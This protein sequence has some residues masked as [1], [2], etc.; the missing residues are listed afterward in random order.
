[1]GDGSC[2]LTILIGGIAIYFILKVEVFSFWEPFSPINQD[3]ILGKSTFANWMVSILKRDTPEHKKKQHPLHLCHPDVFGHFFLRSF[4]KQTDGTLCSPHT[5]PNGRKTQVWV[6]ALE[7]AT[8]AFKNLRKVVWR[9]G[10]PWRHGLFSPLP[11]EMN[12]FDVHIFDMGWTHQ[13]AGFD[14][15]VSQ[16]CR[17]QKDFTERIRK[18]MGRFIGSLK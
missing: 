1:M 3:E 16:E 14:V 18:T 15:F 10:F 8:W 9:C 2:T 7:L 4:W 6:K 12:Q 17:G 13:L 11:G 5:S